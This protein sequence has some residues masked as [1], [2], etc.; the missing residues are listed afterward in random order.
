MGVDFFTL[1]IA[2]NSSGGR[3]RPTPTP[4]GD[5][6]AKKVIERTLSGNVELD[7]IDTVGMYGLSYCTNLRTVTLNNCTSI[8]NSALRDCQTLEEFVGPKVTFVGSNCFTNCFALESVRIGEQASG[9][10]TIESGA[11][12]N[13]YALETLVLPFDTVCVL[14]S[15][16]AFNNTPMASTQYTGNYGKIYVPASLINAYRSASNWSMYAARFAPIN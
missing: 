9:S 10:A 7:D 8:S 13:C 11:F 6:D 4:G 1:A 5:G 15:T 16:T 3:P 14:N 12:T 2:R